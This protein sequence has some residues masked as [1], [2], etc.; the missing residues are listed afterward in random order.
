MTDENEER[1]VFFP[2]D[3]SKPRRLTVAEAEEWLNNNL[4]SSGDCPRDA[5]RNLI[6][7][8]IDTRRLEMAAT[9]SKSMLSRF[10]GDPELEAES[11]MM[12]G[13]IM[14]KM[15]DYTA[16]VTYYER[17]VALEPLDR[18]SSYF[19]HN[20]LGFS[21]NQLERFE[22]GEKCCRRAIEVD[23]A[24]SNAHKNL[25]LALEGQARF[26][27]AAQAYVDA[28][29]ACVSDPRPLNHLSSLLGKRP[30]LCDEFE[31]FAEKQER[32]SG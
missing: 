13:R 15:G 3:G 21:L 18:D 2:N 31:R 19:G 8:H 29:D 11:L 23:P 30:E 26:R 4:R 16:A 7:F 22:E 28:T 6:R 20:N 9:I 14:E 10:K 24:Y 17:V 12:L 27:E 1:F 5:Y 32:R 25:G